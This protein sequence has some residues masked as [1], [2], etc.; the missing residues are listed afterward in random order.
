MPYRRLPNT[1]AARIKALAALTDN[2]DVYTVKGRFL[3]R[4]MIAEAQKMYAQL[5]DAMQLYHS[6]MRTQVR[7]SKR[8]APLQHQAMTFLSHFIQVLFMMVERGEVEAK[9]LIDYG[10][11]PDEMTVP[12]LKTADAVMEWAPKVINAERKRVRAGGKPVLS[13][14]IGAVSTH[15]DV[16]KAMYDAQ[17]QYMTRTQSALSE[18]TRL[19]PKVDN[20]ILNLWNQIEAHFQDQPPETRFQLCRKYGIVYYYRR[21]EKRIEENEI[22]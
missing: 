9:H 3:D 6:S 17:R 2:N 10:F 12:Y 16:F 18:I 14:P 19:R 11:N 15:F 22:H 8:M 20:V 1:D 13:P 5:S 7:Y 21:H 4:K